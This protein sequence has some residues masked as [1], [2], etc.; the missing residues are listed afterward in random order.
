M[1]RCSGRYGVNGQIDRASVLARNCASTAA[2][3]AASAGAVSIDL[4]ELANE[5]HV[6]SVLNAVTLFNVTGDCVNSAAYSPLL[7]SAIML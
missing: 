3:A 1:N 7:P 6:V 5:L 2:V 4:L